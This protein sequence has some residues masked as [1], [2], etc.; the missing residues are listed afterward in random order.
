[1]FKPLP[2]VNED[3]AYEMGK[4]YALNGA[5][6]TNCHFS[7]FS[8]PKNTK[9]WERGRDD[10]SVTPCNAKR[11]VIMQTR[12]ED[13]EDFFAEIYHGRHHIPSKLKGFGDGWSVNH[14]GDLSTF[15]FDT[16]TRLVFLAHDLCMRVSIEQ[17]GPGM[18]KIIVWKRNSREGRMS[19]RHPTIEEAL[20]VWRER[21]TEIL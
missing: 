2:K 20:N 3:Y 9:S 6:T 8:N 7:I 18:V 10:I 12:L 15:D 16:L 1:M 5:N 11:E 17:S 21:H 13:A 4:D 19:S 14:R